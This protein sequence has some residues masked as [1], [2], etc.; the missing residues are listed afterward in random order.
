MFSDQSKVGGSSDQLFSIDCFIGDSANPY[1]AKII[2]LGLI[3]IFFG[4]ILLIT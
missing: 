1:F 4:L 2:L 3:P